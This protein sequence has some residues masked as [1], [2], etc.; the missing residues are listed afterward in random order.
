MALAEQTEI[1]VGFYQRSGACVARFQNY[2]YI[3]SEILITCGT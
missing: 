2:E 1:S 3:L